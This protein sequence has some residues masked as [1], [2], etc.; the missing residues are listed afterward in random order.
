MLIVSMINPHEKEQ[1]F[2][3]RRTGRSS[4]STLNFCDAQGEPGG[5][6]M[7]TSAS[8]DKSIQ[9]RA[10]P[11]RN[12]TV[13]IRQAQLVGAVVGFAGGLFAATS[14][15]VFTVASWFVVNV[16]MRRW[17]STTGTILFFLTIPL[18]IFGGYCMDWMDKDKPRRNSK[19]ARYED[20]DDG[21]QY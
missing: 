10:K 14:G 11:F 3:P 13:A 9:A 21:N 2:S 1:G 8:L 19:A 12:I 7:R 17:L 20:E 16:G 5:D 4:D 6:Y 15:A 18:I